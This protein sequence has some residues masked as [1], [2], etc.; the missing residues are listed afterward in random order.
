MDKREAKELVNNLVSNYKKISE[1]YGK[2]DEIFGISPDCKFFDSVFKMEEEYISVVQKLVGDDTES[3]M[4][5][6]FDNNCGKDGKKASVN[7]K[8]KYIKNVDDLIWLICEG[9]W[10]GWDKT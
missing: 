6:I 4:W 7:G 10:N 1:N 2:L 9:K 3:V 5:Y 8:E